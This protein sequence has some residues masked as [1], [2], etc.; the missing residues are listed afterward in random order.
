MTKPYYDSS[1]KHSELGYMPVFWLAYLVFFFIPYI[2]IDATPAE[3]INNAGVLTVFIVLYFYSFIA[4][5]RK[6]WAI[7]I[8]TLVL[9]AYAAS[10]NPS[11]GTLFI[12]ASVFASTQDKKIDAALGILIAVGSWVAVAM[13]FDINYFQ[14]SFIVVFALVISALNFYEK[15]LKNKNDLLAKSENEKL[16]LAAQA[17]RERLTRDVHDTIGQFVSMVTLKAELVKKLIGENNTR[18][19]EEVK[20]IETISRQALSELR[21]A[22]ANKQKV[23]LPGEI[24]TAKTLLDYA[25]IKSSWDFESE[26]LLNSREV[27]TIA[28]VVRELVNNILKHSDGSHC[29]FTLASMNSEAVLRVSSTGGGEAFKEGNGLAGIRQRVALLEGEC[30]IQ[31]S[32]GQFEVTITFPTHQKGIMQDTAA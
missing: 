25:S 32:E 12:Y 21:L 8:A 4:S 5:R 31:H 3:M 27:E 19:K 7:T 26:V 23:D 2:W 10:Y 13:A 15:Q 16:S 29:S 18:A 6:L 17:E 28:M 24:A 11:A 30:D 20:D 22:I 9:A 14:A 1:G